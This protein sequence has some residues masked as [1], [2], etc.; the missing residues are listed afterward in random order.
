MILSVTLSVA[1][2]LLLG[3]TILNGR[4]MKAGI[5]EKPLIYT[6]VFV[7]FILN[8]FMLAFFGLST[9]LLF[10]YSWKLFLLLLLIGFITEVFI[11]VPTI[12]WILYFVFKP[13]I[14]KGRKIEL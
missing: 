12:E 7:Q 3:F 13:L 4:Y 8:I 1:F 9:F 5:G 2:L 11:V 14:K 6:S 10:F